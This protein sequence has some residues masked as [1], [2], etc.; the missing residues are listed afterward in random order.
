MNNTRS[1]DQNILF[2][3]T[4]KALPDPRR[5]EKGNFRYPLIEI[6][7]LV[8]S[9]VISNA[10]D[11]CSISTFGKSQLNWLRKFFP[12]KNGTPSHD[13]LGELFASIDNEKFNECFVEWIKSAQDII[14][15]GIVTIDGKRL[16]GSYDKG[17]SKAAIH[18]V[19]AFAVENGICLGQKQTGAKSN[20]ITAI[21][22][23]LDLLELKGAIVTID[24]MGCQKSIVEQLDQKEAGYVIA[25]KENQE[26][27]YEQVKKMFEINKGV[28]HQD[29]DSGHGRVEIRTCTV[30][31]QLKFF[32]T[33]DQWA[34]LKSVVKIEAQR[35]TKLDGKTQNETRYYISNCSANAERLNYIVRKHWSIENQ[36]HWVL[37]VIFNEDSSRRRMKN[38]AANFNIIL[39]TAMAILK[40][41][42]DKKTSLNRKRYMAAL[43]R[44]YRDKLLKT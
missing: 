26:E 7:F 33:K 1:K 35:T 29:V 21:P 27:L 17:S 14:G 44:D 41:D 22:K 38:S 32:D 31:D 19:S 3:E 5:I 40:K 2:S 30:V 11:W 15:G 36:L 28:S 18:M 43:D 24:A 4:F 42:T 39:K 9:A 25:V 34:G 12:Y 13:T 10:D 8:I 20:E 6:I 37:D 16:R 23:L